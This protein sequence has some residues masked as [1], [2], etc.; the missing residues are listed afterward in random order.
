MT[1]LIDRIEADLHAGA[2][3]ARQVL[4]HHLTSINLATE[5]AQRASA[6]EGSPV[7][8]ALEATALGP[9]GEAIVAN[10]VHDAAALMAGAG[11]AAQQAAAP[12]AP[13][14]ADAPEVPDP[15]AQAAQ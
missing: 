13:G 9:Q 12:A 7:L 10:W 1:T 6:A 11:A 4:A 14:D 5:L 2:A 15:A 3:D 8:Q